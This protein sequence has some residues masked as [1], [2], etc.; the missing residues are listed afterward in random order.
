MNTIKSLAKNTI[1]ALF[2]FH[3]QL[4][5]ADEVSERVIASMGMPAEERATIVCEGHEDSALCQ[6]LVTEPDY[7]DLWF[8]TS[9]KLNRAEWI[10]AERLVALQGQIDTENETIQYMIERAPKLPDG[11]PIFRDQDGNF[12]DLDGQPIS[13]GMAM[14]A[15]RF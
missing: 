7:R 10:L 9:D 3:P 4:S 14:T 13:S 1:L 15:R 2:V 6:K 11:R 5:F 12:F 8:E